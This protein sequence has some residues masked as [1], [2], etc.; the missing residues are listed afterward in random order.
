MAK[1]GTPTYEKNVIRKNVPEKKPTL[2][3]NKKNIRQKNK[4]NN[5]TRKKSLP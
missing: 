4:K 2:Y 5:V 1:K 3:G